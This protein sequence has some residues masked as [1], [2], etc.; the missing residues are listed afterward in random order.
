M[1]SCIV[2]R[3]VLLSIFALADCSVAVAKPKA[4]QR[5]DAFEEYREFNLN[6]DGYQ[7]NRDGWIIRVDRNR[8]FNEF[9]IKA[10]VSTEKWPSGIVEG[11]ENKEEGLFPFEH[12]RVHT[13][14]IDG[15]AVSERLKG[16]QCAFETISLKGIEELSRIVIRG[17]IPRLEEKTKWYGLKKD[18]DWRRGLKRI[19]LENQVVGL[20]NISFLG[21]VKCLEFG[22]G[23]EAQICQRW[24]GGE[25]LKDLE[26]CYGLEQLEI[27]YC[28]ATN[29]AIHWGELIRNSPL[30]DREVVSFSPAGNGVERSVVLLN[31]GAS[32]EI[33]DYV[34]TIRADAIPADFRKSVCMPF[35]VREVIG[36][37]IPQKL[38]LAL[39]KGSL[40][41]SPDIT[42][43]ADTQRL[44]KSKSMIKTC[45]VK[46]ATAYCGLSLSNSVGTVD[47]GFEPVGVSWSSS[48]SL[49]R[50]K[51][52]ENRIF[53]HLKLSG[54]SYPV[55]IT[56]LNGRRLDSISLTFEREALG[57]GTFVLGLV[58]S[59]VIILVLLAGVWF[60][61]IRQG[62]G[63][64]R[65]ALA[66][67]GVC[68]GVLVV[69]L[70]LNDIGVLQYYVDTYLTGAAMSYLNS[71]FVSS[72]VISVSVTVVKLVIGFLQ[73]LKLSL[74][75]VGMDINSVFQPV[76][77]VL[78][79]ISTYSWISTCVLAFVRIV[80]QV[81]RDGAAF[82]WCVLGSSLA[83]LSIL[84]L[85]GAGRGARLSGRLVSVAMFLAL[86]IPIVLCCCAWFS[87]RLSD[88]SG[89][90]FNQSMTD[91][92]LL[93]QSCSWESL[94]SMAAVQV[95]LSQFTDAVSGLIS[96]AMYYIATKAFDCFL[97][98]LM[99]YVGLK[100]SLK[101]FSDGREA[102][103]VQI[104][105]ILAGQAHR[106]SEMRVPLA[107]DGEPNARL[108]GSEG[109]E[110]LPE[111]RH[112]SRCAERPYSTSRL[113]ALCKWL[114]PEWITAGAAVV[115]CLLF[116]VTALRDVPS[117]VVENGNG[118]E[119]AP[120]L[121]APAPK[122]QPSGSFTGGELAFGVLAFAA[123][124]L[125]EF[126]CFRKAKGVCAGIQRNEL[127][128]KAQDKLKMLNESS[129][130]L[131]L[132]LYGGLGG[133][134]LGFLI[135][136]I[137][138]LEY[139]MVG[140]RIV[141]YMST[142]LGIGATWWIQKKIV[143]P[144]KTKLMEQMAQEEGA[145]E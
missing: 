74:V 118:T 61:G 29:T 131:D 25:G 8:I 113:P 18:D 134:V 63:L 138:K 15:D 50:G 89:A 14:V 110:G 27:P 10:P 22:T 67:F 96:S 90:A 79:K 19:V 92:T 39:K 117:A 47:S 7:V 104:R 119:S 107:A 28:M 24:G 9:V 133:T 49:L 109:A 85:F 32:G 108:P 2:N 114:K 102:E 36:G 91:F 51:D 124:L 66:S 95:L 52:L 12:A 45:P 130:W 4:E 139:L 20:T 38:T 126:W 101:G 54:V 128:K 37:E 68:I 48:L 1:K 80:C 56:T 83:A 121:G 6:A 75:F 84:N 141:A 17:Q 53:A 115:L 46:I 142:L 16:G 33:S 43:R 125:F 21:E 76:Q 77:D 59:C 87:Y 106:V 13:L 34:T 41:F 11:G 5:A 140:G 60:F 97:V 145:H 136:S 69:F 144:Y 82:V 3:I 98:P 40:L 72:L 103:L 71:S 70:G 94:K 44:S 132:P 78:E 137:P 55:C 122:H 23:T 26:K 93:A 31:I 135:I 99:L 58:A 81:L 143:S 62:I 73:G 86:G 57:W 129:Y 100:M 30:K 123:F 88:I 116:A 42:D 111:L 35:R 127:V 65:M 112:Q 120:V 105:E 64:K